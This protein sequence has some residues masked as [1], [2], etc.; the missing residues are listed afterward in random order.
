[1][2]D[3]IMKPK[4]ISEKYELLK[5]VVKGISRDRG[6]ELIYYFGTQQIRIRNQPESRKV[7][8]LRY[9]KKIRGNV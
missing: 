7:R 3:L 4:K 9:I 5:L 6:V 1:M 8:D 2:E